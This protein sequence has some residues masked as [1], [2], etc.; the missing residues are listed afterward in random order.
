MGPRETGCSPIRRS[1]ILTLLCFMLVCL[2]LLDSN[3]TICKNFSDSIRSLFLIIKFAVDAS[4]FHINPIAYCV[5][6]RD[7]PSILLDVINVYLLL[8]FSGYKSPF[9]D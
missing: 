3:C 5:V 8:I 4:C 1:E 7:L 9:Y 6:I 2:S